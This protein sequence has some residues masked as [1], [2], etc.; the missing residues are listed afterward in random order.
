MKEEEDMI[1]LFLDGGRRGI[2]NNTY[3]VNVVSLFVALFMFQSL[4]VK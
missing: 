1:D 3:L 2:C 4:M